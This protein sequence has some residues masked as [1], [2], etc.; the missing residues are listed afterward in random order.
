MFPFVDLLFLLSLLYCL[1]SLLSNFDNFNVS[2]ARNSLT[3]I[4]S[5]NFAWAS[6]SF[7]LLRLSLLR[8]DVC[9]PAFGRMLRHVDRGQ[10]G[11]Y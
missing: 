10:K 6:E 8:F 2:C 3:K 5:F 4:A 1:I 11:C 7:L 9:H